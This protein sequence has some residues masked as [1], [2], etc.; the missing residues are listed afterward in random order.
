M[1][2]ATHRFIGAA[3]S[4]QRRVVDLQVQL[5]MV[6]H[7]LQLEANFLVLHMAGMMQSTA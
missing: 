4:L 2:A 6:K 7:L 5:Q 3:H 1:V